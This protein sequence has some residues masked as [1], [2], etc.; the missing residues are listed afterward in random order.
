MSQESQAVTT[1]MME[2][3]RDLYYWYS[4]YGNFR[5]PI[6]LFIHNF[7]NISPYKTAK[8]LQ[9]IE[10]VYVTPTVNT[11]K[12]YLKNVSRLLSR[13]QFTESSCFHIPF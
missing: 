3:G 9:S 11:L 10:F 1:R 5:K 12:S 2:E 7:F 8:K 6:I 13:L 4:I